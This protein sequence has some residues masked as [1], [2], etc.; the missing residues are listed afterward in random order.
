MKKVKFIKCI[1]LSTPI[2]V[3]PLIAS[4]CAAYNVFDLSTWDNKHKQILIDYVLNYVRENWSNAEK[5]NPWAGGELFDAIGHAFDS[6][7]SNLDDDNGNITWTWNNNYQ[8]T[9]KKALTNGV[10]ATFVGHSFPSWEQLQSVKG[11]MTVTFKGS[12]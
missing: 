4:S 1:A 10:T 9:V 3:T 12:V 2:V 11:K 5:N 8:G 6:I 7:N